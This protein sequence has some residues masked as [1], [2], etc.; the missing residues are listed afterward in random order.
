MFAENTFENLAN[1]I[2]LSKN[3]LRP[4][5]V[6]LNRCP[7]VTNSTEQALHLAL[8]TVGICPQTS[9]CARVYKGGNPVELTFGPGTFTDRSSIVSWAMDVITPKINSIPGF[10]LAVAQHSD[11]KWHHIFVLYY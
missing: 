11:L 3:T 2:I 7:N 10:V 6:C 9:C 4:A 1:S 8:N 5:L